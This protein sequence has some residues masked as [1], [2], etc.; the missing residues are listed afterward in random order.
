MNLTETTVAGQPWAFYAPAAATTVEAA[1]DLAG[2]QPGESFLDLGCGDGRVLVAAGRRG[3]RVRGVE[4]D[5]DLAE[6]ARQ[7]LRAAGIDGEVEVRDMFAEP[8][9]GD[10][11]YAYLTPVTLARLRPL[12]AAAGHGGRIVTPRYGIAGLATDRH[13]AGCYLYH[14]PG[15]PESAPRRLGWVWRA[16]L[17]VAPA[18]RRCLVPLTLCAGEGALTLEVDEPLR[19]RAR[20]AVG[21]KEMAAAGTVPVDL[22]FRPHGAGSVV[23]GSVRAQ[24]AAITVAAIFADSG[25]GQWKFGPGEGED[26]RR[27][28]DVRTALAHESATPGRP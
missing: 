6:L 10:V 4:I 23:A 14:L 13:G 3:A 28:L 16:T 18:D 5:A 2:V 27:E 22:I 9:M 8:P 19:R 20:Y 11:L 7:N 25:F 24:G 17:V 26:F 1:L 12:L 15:R 21:P